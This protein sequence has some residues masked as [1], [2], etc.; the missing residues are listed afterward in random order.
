MD[1]SAIQLDQRP[2][3][4][5]ELDTELEDLQAQSKALPTLCIHNLTP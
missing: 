4:S 2:D 5:A 3:E 1:E